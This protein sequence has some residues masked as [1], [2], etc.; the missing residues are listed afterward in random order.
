MASNYGTFSVSLRISTTGFII[1][2]ELSVT[3]R[4]AEAG[5][6]PFSVEAGAQKFYCF[7]KGYLT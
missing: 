1:L 4:D 2:D 6:G 3:I 7:R 5:S